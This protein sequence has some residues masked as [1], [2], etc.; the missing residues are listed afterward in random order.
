MNS[1]MRRQQ[2]ANNARMGIEEFDLR[3][4]TSP[5]VSRVH[6]SHW[7]VTGLWYGSRTVV[8]ESDPDHAEFIQ[9]G[10]CHQFIR[11]MEREHGTTE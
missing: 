8:F 11:D 10:D 1:Q 9:L 3:I 4:E 5:R 7:V 6:P 2:A